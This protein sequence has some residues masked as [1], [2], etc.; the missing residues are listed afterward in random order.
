MTTPRAEAVLEG[1]RTALRERLAS[2]EIS[3]REVRVEAARLW[4]CEPDEVQVHYDAEGNV[5]QVRFP[6]EKTIIVLTIKTEKE[7]P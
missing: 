7:K 3:L 5:V 4:D 6:P 1:L 2:G